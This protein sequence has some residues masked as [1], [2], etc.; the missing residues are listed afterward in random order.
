MSGKQEPIG[1][2][3]KRS[4]LEIMTTE[5]HNNNKGPSESTTIDGDDAVH[6]NNNPD[7]NDDIALPDTIFS[8]LQL[9]AIFYPKFENEQQQQDDSNNK[10]KIRAAMRER[11]AAGAG[12]LEVSVKH[13][14]SLLL[15]SGGSRFYS[16][17][18]SDNP[19]TWTGEVLLRQHFVRA[20]WNQE[21]KNSDSLQQQ[22]ASDMY[23][24]CSDFCEQHRLTLAFEV[25]T[26]FLG[27][28]GDIPA[29]DF[30]ILTA[31]ADRQQQAF[32]ATTQLL[33][34]A[35]QF[36]LPH[37][38]VWMFTSSSSSPSDASSSSSSAVDQLLDL[39]DT[40]R[41]TGTA[42]SVVPQLS[43]A[44]Q[45]H[46][47]SL[48]PHDV[49]QGD[50]MEG[51]VIRYVAVAADD[52]PRLLLL[53]QRM[54]GLAQKSRELRQAVPPER[55][56]C[57]DLFLQ[58]HRGQ[59]QQQQHL[60]DEVLCTDLRTLFHDGID[61]SSAEKRLADLL[62]RK[63]GSHRVSIQRV[64]RKEDIP[65]RTVNLA[66]DETIDNESRQIAKLIQTLSTLISDRVDY[67]VVRETT[68]TTTGS[69]PTETT[70]TTTTRWL[71][72]IHV[73][74]D[75]TF[76]KYRRLSSSRSMELFRG[77]VFEINPNDSNVA[78]SLSN[79]TALSIH[80]NDSD[81]PK[82]EPLM[83]KMKF[84]PYMVRTFGC[85]NGLPKVKQ[86]GPQAFSRHAAEL[87]SR[88][89]ISRQGRDTW[90]PYFD[91]WGEYAHACFT[92]QQRGMPE[93]LPPLTANNYLI[94]LRE[95][96]KQ[97]YKAGKITMRQGAERCKLRGI[98]VVVA[99]RENVAI[100]VADYIAEQLGGA[101]RVDG[102]STLRR[103]V[104]DKACGPGGGI[105]YAVAALEGPNPIRKLLKEF[106]DFIS[107]VLFQLSADDVLSNSGEADKKA[108]GIAQ[109]WRKTN[110]SRQYSLP[111]SSL[112]ADAAGREEVAREDVAPSKEFS[113]MVAALSNVKEET[114]EG[115]GILVFFPG[116]PGCGKS[117]LAGHVSVD[118]L[119]NVRPGAKSKP[120]RKLLVLVGD[121]TKK[122]YW[123]VVQDSRKRD[124]SS[125]VIADKN[126]P[127]ISFET[128]STICFVTK[129]LAVPVLP[130]VLALQTTEVH[131]IRSVKN[132][133][134][135]DKKHVYP[136][137]LAYLAVCLARVV[138]RPPGSHAGKLDR[139]TARAC[140][141][142]I[143]FYG[144]YRGISA[145]ELILRMHSRFTC[146][147][148]LIT[149]PIE[150]PFL[151][152]KESLPSEL[153]SLL[154]EALRVQVS[155][156]L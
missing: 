12:Y 60:Q 21:V 33:Q 85:R 73:F 116:I 78:S 156:G 150:V 98:V 89:K 30:L 79:S 68:K 32:Y 90:Q 11:V 100:L 133:K 148:A 14:G 151:Q 152:R 128:I 118:E 86:G 107:V 154:L 16:K 92:R 153:K 108:Q 10:N 132:D 53:L 7:N 74:Y 126:A 146:S 3:R 77:F 67:S 61:Q 25:V 38:D 44:A 45:V 134:S 75:K 50:I 69:V 40:S 103:D 15:W 88:W 122:K 94:H 114:D 83:L 18:S 121:A 13:S 47:C 56:S 80:S 43:A 54:H 29:R 84:L 55:P 106:G 5:E 19:Y 22:K 76:Q 141:V 57:P 6:H 120:A 155:V 136:F 109:S 112:F 9:E 104:A 91:A 101:R 142:V 17:N 143:K 81:S 140:M 66:W 39:Y 87:L 72:T 96:E 62:R 138:S 70:T 127:P 28:H 137:S 24:R 37:N 4:L 129:A 145:E 64:S 99:P 123:S 97:Y 20:F 130:D 52:E 93:G 147:G 8:Q 124:T 139:A 48:Y 41:E 95:F 42:R 46:V 34:F 2:G 63:H 105:V 71:C 117:F 49:F 59:Q 131:G 144:F 51:L 23:Q 110:C 36:R 58:R 113:D 26:S 82:E 65:S 111:F 135:Q 27:H 31:I 119:R 149:S 115:P 35:Q 102:L 1:V 125:V